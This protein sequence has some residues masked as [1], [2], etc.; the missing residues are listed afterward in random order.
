MTI[1]EQCRMYSGFE[2]AVFR[3]HFALAGVLTDIQ[4][5]TEFSVIH[6]HEYAFACRGLMHK[7]LMHIVA[8]EITLCPVTKQRFRHRS[9]I[10]RGVYGKLNS[11]GVA[12][13]IR[14]HE[15]GSLEAKS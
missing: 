6:Q 2:I 10:I 3:E 15:E 1:L 12:E 7:R 11:A 13:I 5:L 4:F 9:Q 14:L 8:F